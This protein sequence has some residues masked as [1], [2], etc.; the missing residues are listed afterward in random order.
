MGG[1]DRP[2]QKIIRVEKKFKLDF[3]YENWSKKMAGEMFRHPNDPENDMW[4]KWKISHVDRNKKLS[5]L[6]LTI[7]L[8][9]SQFSRKTG[10]WETRKEV[11]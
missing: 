10:T 9:L 1:S 5:D 11:F 2:L 7:F 8:L 4:S 3:W 6:V